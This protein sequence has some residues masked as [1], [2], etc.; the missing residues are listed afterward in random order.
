MWVFAR[1]RR[2]CF[3]GGSTRKR[4][5]YV[6]FGPAAIMDD[7]FTEWRLVT[8]GRLGHWRTDR[9]DDFTETGRSTHSTQRA[10]VHI[11]RSEK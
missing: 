7:D 4:V 6:G 3:G 10:G 9:S 5:V 8:L 2:W 11:L 1:V